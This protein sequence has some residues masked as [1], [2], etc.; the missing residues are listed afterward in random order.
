[1][2]NESAYRDTYSTVNPL[3][4]VFERAILRRCCG[5]QHAI[6]RNIAE[7]EAAGCQEA[8]AHATCTALKQQMRNA[9]AF[10]LKLAHPDEPLPHG[11][12]LK[13]QC[14]GLLGIARLTTED[15]I[16]DVSDIYAALLAAIKQYGSL[17]LLPYQDVMQAIH[18]YE[19]RSH[20]KKK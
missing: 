11:K 7:R 5:C 2:L 13:L 14:G 3:Q 6:R 10:T 4:C 1:M 17:D 20:R 15:G 16:S 18:A 8:S 19:P 9:A 12:E